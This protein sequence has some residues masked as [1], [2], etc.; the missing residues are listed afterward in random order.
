MIAT[1]NSE[2]HDFDRI[3]DAK[4]MGAY[5]TD[6]QIADFLAW[7]AIRSPHE[8]I[9][10]PSFGAGVFLRSGSRRLT[11]LGGQPQSQVYGAEIDA[12]VFHRVS[13]RLAGENVLNGENLLLGDFFSVDSARLK[14]DVAIGNP[15][16][17]RYQRFTGEMRKRA[18]ARCM[19]QGVRLP[20]LCSSWAPFLVHT[21]AMLRLGGRLA[22]V[23]PMEVGH[24]QYAQPVLEHL[25][26]SFGS[27]TFLTFREKLFPELSED[28][29]LLLAD[30]FG[31]AP[32]RFLWRD[33]A[34]LSELT[35]L[36]ENDLW[37]LPH[38]RVLDAPAVASGSTRL[39]ESFIPEKARSLYHDL[40]KSG[41]A[42]R[43][44]K[45]ADVG[46]GYVT[47][48]N[49]YFHLSPRGAEQYRIPTEYLKPAIR[50][51]RALCGL[52]FTPVD[53]RKAV[54]RKEAGFLLH[55]GKDQSLS[56][57]VR[58]YLDE[59]ESRRIHDA[60]KCRMRRPWY[61]VPHVYL[62]DA[63]LMYMSGAMPRLV[64]NDARVYAPNS[65]HILRL[66]PSAQIPSDAL[67]ALWQ[68]SL[69]RL[70]VEIEGHAL[71][72]GMLK[73]EPTEA[74][75]VLIPC[76]DRRELPK[77]VELS[78]ELD[79]LARKVGDEA[80]RERADQVILQDTMGLSKD[81]CRLL[82]SAAVKLRT[83]RGYGES[84]HGAA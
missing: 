75:N 72:G 13:N 31:A 20:E 30:E 3:G 60:Y 19:D 66:H 67:A 10:D 1:I 61:S 43:L 22:M 71:G 38:T 82:R 2:A 39:I 32:A 45:L 24:A 54:E 46:I 68:T 76:L 27:V 59:G 18:L 12:T 8:T 4:S 14:V 47:G 53:W 23:L 34:H 74:E 79:D 42:Q 56:K 44:G 17:I 69:T 21:M 9:L 7:W 64:A 52:R 40:M 6:A 25:R 16:F 51:G 37:P 80:A 81:E 78:S 70:S 58:K 48:A 55:I 41:H 62:P 63:F 57:T 73:L 33:V 77:L 65:L 28:T 11:Q 26:R 36:R 83:R 49:D 15:P 29:V 35:V 5:Y 84:A 50:R